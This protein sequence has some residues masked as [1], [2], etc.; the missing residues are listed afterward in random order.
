MLGILGE[1]VAHVVLPAVRAG[2]VPTPPALLEGA[3]VSR[4]ER[5]GLNRLSSRRPG[6]DRTQKDTRHSPRPG[7]DVALSAIEGRT[8]EDRLVG[9]LLVQEV[10]DRP[11]VRVERGDLQRVAVLNPA[12]VDVVVE[13][14]GPRGRGR[15]LLVL[16]T[17]LGEDQ[18]LRRDGHLQQIH[19]RLEISVL[20]LEFQLDLALVDPLLQLGDRVADPVGKVIDRLVPERQKAL[21]ANRDLSIPSTGQET[22][23]DGPNQ[24]ETSRRAGKKPDS[25]TVANLNH[26]ISPRCSAKASI[27]HSTSLCRSI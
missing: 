8:H 13:I 26:L 18:G 1:D 19:D 20:G 15:D 7:R 4:D 17:G 21:V 5:V 3:L 12:E 6:E 22:R 2:D 27:R 24:G 25:A 10:E 14:E 23:D 9:W 11:L 16:K